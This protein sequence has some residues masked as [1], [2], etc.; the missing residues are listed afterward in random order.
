[1]DVS[2]PASPLY[3]FSTFF[4]KIII[5]IYSEKK[6]T[7]SDTKLREVTVYVQSR[8]N[9]YCIRCQNAGYA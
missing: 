2:I 8:K 6:Y 4:A 1:M 9:G 7:I 5:A 3:G